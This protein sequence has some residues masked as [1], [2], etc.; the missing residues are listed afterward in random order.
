MTCQLKA[1]DSTCV[2]VGVWITFVFKSTR[3]III[4]SGMALLGCGSSDGRVGVAGA[5]TLDGKPLDNGVI[6]FLSRGERPSSG[7]AA[8]L[9]GKYEI[10]AEHGLLPGKYQ[11]AIDAADPGDAQA[12]PD[13]P[14]MAIPVS[15]IPLRY[16]G[17]T[18]LMAEISADGENQFDF[19]LEG[20]SSLTVG[21]TN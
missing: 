2:L 5:V 1:L 11:V 7:G 6:T 13:H 17:E 10:P 20:G 15:K 3:Y 8:I 18:E 4:V 16:N 19:P 12:R 9:A 14:G 21:Q